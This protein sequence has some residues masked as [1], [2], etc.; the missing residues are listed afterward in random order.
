DD[1]RRWKP[2]PEIY[3]HAARTCRVTP[4][5]VALVAAHAWDTHG[6]RQAGLQTGWVARNGNRYPTIFTAP[7]VTG[8]GLGEVIDALLALP[9]SA[10]DEV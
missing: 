6:A 5:R 9:P 1:V 7:D 10:S 2:A 4:G 8:S 3:L